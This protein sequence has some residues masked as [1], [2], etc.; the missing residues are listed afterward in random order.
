M[1]EKPWKALFEKIGVAR[2]QSHLTAGPSVV[3]TKTGVIGVGIGVTTSPGNTTE[4][5]VVDVLVHEGVSGTAL[6]LVTVAEAE[7]IAA[8]VGVTTTM[9]GLKTNAVAAEV[10]A[11]VGVSDIAVGIVS[12]HTA[13]E[14]DVADGVRR[15]RGT[16]DPS[17]VV[18]TDR[19]VPPTPVSRSG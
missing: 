1:F 2:Y 13:P 3:L 10:A 4:Q 15:I 9:P 6:G 16:I 19:S 5:V 14:E 8:L 17:I 12:V 18:P 7:E 11:L